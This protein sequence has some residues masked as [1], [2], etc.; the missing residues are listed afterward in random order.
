M[1]NKVGSF[2]CSKF[3]V[4]EECRGNVS[5]A[6]EINFAYNIFYYNSFVC[7]ITCYGCHFD[8]RMAHDIFFLIFFR[9]E[10]G[11]CLNFKT[12]FD[13][14]LTPKYTH[15]SYTPTPPPQC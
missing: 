2:F 5:T 13:R 15:I 1:E 7:C 8:V 3:I 11:D 14:T 4:K 6:Q 10:C 9:F 12:I